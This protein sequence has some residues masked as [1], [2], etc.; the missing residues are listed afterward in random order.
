MKELLGGAQ[1]CTHLAELLGSVATTAFQTLSPVRL[2]RP[3][4]RN[5]GAP[6]KID[7]CY[8]YASTGELVRRRWPEFYMGSDKPEE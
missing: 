2:A 6:V 4:V 5:G 1:G 3:E 7:S 8:A